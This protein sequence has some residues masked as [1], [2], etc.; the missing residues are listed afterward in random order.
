MDD[1]LNPQPGVQSAELSSALNHFVS[2]VQRVQRT[3][4]EVSRLFYELLSRA[5]LTGSISLLSEDGKYLAVK[6][7]AIAGGGVSLIEDVSGSQVIGLPIPLA[8][9]HIYRQVLDGGKT[10]FEADISEELRRIIPADFPDLKEYVV[11]TLAEQPTVFAP[12][13]L[14]AHVQGVLT[15]SG[16]GISRVDAPLVEAFANHVSVALEN[17]RLASTVRV[18]AVERQLAKDALLESEQKYRSIVHQS[19]DGII[20]V[21]EEGI[22]IEWNEA[23]E[24][25]TG[26]ARQEAIGRLI[27]ELQFSL[28]P[29]P[30]LP[31]GMEAAV[32]QGTK[33]F[34]RTGSSPWMDQPREQEILRLDGSR[35]TI[36]VVL[37]PLK[38][39]KGY[40]VCSIVRDVTERKEMERAVERRA[41]ELA[42]LQAQS[43]ELTT[44]HELPVLLR[45]IVE[46]A[47]QLLGAKGGSLYL[48]EPDKQLVRLYVVIQGAT[49][50][51][52]GSTLQYG[53]G[54]A[55]YVALSG[56]PLIVD[57]Y[58]AWSGRAKVYESNPMFS[59]ILTVPMIW[60]GEVTGVLQILE[61]VNFRKFTL[62]DQELLSLF[63]NHAAV[64]LETTRLLEVERRRRQEAETL[65][66]A[67]S[68][69]TS[70][71]ELDELL[72]SILTHL[73]Q[74][75][76]FDSASIFLLR[77]E[78]L[79]IVAARGFA[80]TQQ[81]VGSSLPVNNDSLFMELQRSAHSLILADAQTDVRFNAYGGVEHVRGWL[82]VPLIVRGE[83][84]GCLTL[85]SCQPGIFT[86]THA[87]LAEVFASQAATAIERARLFNVERSLRSQAEATRDAARVISSSLSLNE[88]LAAVLEQ[89]ARVLPYDSGN[90]MLIEHQQAVIKVWRGYPHQDAVQLVKSVCFDL[91]PDSAV[92]YV[93]TTGESLSIADVRR[94]SR[95][96][97]TQL[98]QHIHSWL[99]VPLI[100]R[101][102]VIGLFNLDRTTSQ[103]FSE[104]DLALVQTFAAHAVAAIENA[105]LFE[106]A[107][108]ERR[109]LRLI[110][111]INRSLASS[112]D[113]IDILTRAVTLTCQALGGVV[114]QAFFYKPEDE[115]LQLCALYGKEDVDVLEVDNRINIHLGVGLSGWVAQNRQPAY[116][117][118]VNQDDRWLHVHGLDDGIHSALIA[119]ILYGER[120]CGVLSVL[121]DERSAFSHDHLDLLVAICQEVGLALSN[122]DRYLQ[123]ERKLA[124]MTLIQNLALIFNQRLELRV[125]LDEVVNQLYERFHY[126]LVEIFLLSGE[127]LILQSFRGRQPD[128]I[129]QSIQRGIVGRVARTG[130]IN[131][132]PDTAQDPDYY[133]CSPNTIAELAVPIC[134]DDRVIGVINIETHLPNQLTEHDRELLQ[135]LAGQ[136]SIALENA[137]LYEQVRSHA[138][139]LEHTVEQRTAELTSLFELNQNIGYTLSYDELMRL[140]LDHLMS[141]IGSDITAGWLALDGY[142]L[143]FVQSRRNMTGRGLSSLRT[144]C[145]NV[146]SQL[147]DFTG[148]LE[149]TPIEVIHAASFFEPAETIDQIASMMHV[150]IIIGRK[151]VGILVAGDE[152]GATFTPSQARLLETFAHQAATAI[153]RIKAILAAEQK[154]LEDLVEHLPVGVLLLDLDYRLLVSNP[155]A[156][157]I[158]SALEVEAED[159]F[160]TQIG[161]H[162]L[163]ELLQHYTDPV[164]VEIVHEGP[165]RRFF[166]VQIP[167]MG[168]NHQNWVIMLRDV[169]QERE[170]QVR[171]QM[172]D[173]LATVGQLAAG[174]AHDF[175]NIMA[176]ILVYADLLMGDPSLSKSGRDRLTIIEQQV[177]R[178]A[179]LI[180]QILDFSRR[181]VMEQSSLDILPF[182]KEL[183]RML[184]RVMP[185]TIRLELAYKPGSYLVKADPTRLQQV[186]INLAV[187]ARDAMPQGGVLHFG[188]NRLLLEPGVSPPCP[189]LP[190]GGWIVIKIRDDGAGIPEEVLP[191]I[192][193]PFF[194]TKPVGQ[195]TGL[196]LAQVYGIIKQ[197]GGYIDVSSQIGAGTEFNIYLPAIVET[198]PERR[199]TEPFSPLD[200]MGKVVLVVEDDN[201]TLA[202]LRALLESKNYDVITA[203]DGYEALQQ[204][205]QSR[206]QISL[207]V[208]DVVMP[209]MDGVALYK[210]LQERAPGMKILFVTGHPLEGENQAFLEGGGVHWLQ[211]PFSAREFTR[212]VQNLLEV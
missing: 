35:R 200:G 201:A 113:H 211:K 186:F 175:N 207:V 21:D 29:A 208:S 46:R 80:A 176:A 70:T 166:E 185:E 110:F 30:Y 7:L 161:E 146:L 163:D 98:S 73:E 181:A 106:Q 9:S 48:C 51:K 32:T 24:R 165:P 1:P 155:L 196:G 39:E 93:V 156:R 26:I 137:V 54:A 71:L 43:L 104:N 133:C 20:L 178:A 183:E 193:E 31:D 204:F 131:F 66:K 148:K 122:A 88:V 180:R 107:A 5:D 138:E 83:V 124:E 170:N 78:S 212:V 157:E 135:V 127:Q 15:I 103:V 184:A 49:Q 87:G 114:G 210:A 111:D 53:E 179:S 75:V 76:P 89:L 167:K 41:E 154:R 90:I 197:H 68:A 109:H 123:I 118:D 57:D 202:A 121:H 116:V 81:I 171:I 162:S 60:Q 11:T 47:V 94:D 189:D 74:V 100:I 59:G 79:R 37:F 145:L 58:S 91:S 199:Q 13:I 119:P 120:L 8:N 149:S 86:Q 153:Q 34:L 23:Q 205:E 188:L 130:I 10:I 40:R 52:L 192:Y 194:T 63:A 132:I 112:L 164:P 105:R 174:I 6:A 209:Q 27:W 3:E 67:A 61:D 96:Q 62:A 169:T 82:G 42:A 102:E 18:Q 33:E 2:H 99:G 206:A 92:G 19:V 144:Y 17:A 177:Q 117:E 25:I 28:Y 128:V 159:G 95:W 142:R 172:Q 187:N 72:D 50:E 64:A 69:L 38:T 45:K 65:G 140:L 85:D 160:L 56:K 203:R 126:P 16:R 152:A 195:G 173:R 77:D 139:E 108:T 147:G 150:P 198:L 168:E 115:R 190:P 143:I 55:G 129:V 191:H 44:E 182:F 36:Q 97:D 4:S 134:R 14:D 158:L 125:L 151:N 22:V 101:G 136:I 141:A 12:I 84:I